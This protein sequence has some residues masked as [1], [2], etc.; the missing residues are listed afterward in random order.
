VRP[1]RLPVIVA[2]GTE[3]GPET[4]AVLN[5]PRGSQAAIDEIEHCMERALIELG[6]LP[7]DAFGT[8]RPTPTGPS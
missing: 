6:A 7:P 3:P 4:D 8:T 1:R 2:V 5:A